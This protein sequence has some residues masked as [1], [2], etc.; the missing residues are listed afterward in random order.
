[1]I[2]VNRKAFTSFAVGLSVGIVGVWAQFMT[3]NA[4]TDGWAMLSYGCF[5]VALLSFTRCLRLRGH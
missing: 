3:S 2:S 1:M 5:I 4:R